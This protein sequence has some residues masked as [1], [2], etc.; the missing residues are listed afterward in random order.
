MKRWIHSS[1]TIR[2]LIEKIDLVVIT[3]DARTLTLSSL[4]VVAASSAGYSKDYDQFTPQE[5]MELDDSELRKLSSPYAL[6]ALMEAINSEGFQYT[7]TKK[8]KDILHD[9]YR[10]NNNAFIQLDPSEINELTQM[11]A[12]CKHVTRPGFRK[13]QPEKNFAEAHGLKMV[14][15]DYLNIIHDIKPNEFKRALK[16]YEKDRLGVPLYE[17]IHDPNGYEL[18]YSKQKIEAKIIIYIKLLVNYDGDF[19]V[20]IISFHDPDAETLSDLE[21]N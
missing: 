20:A 10:N 4:P 7:L 8:Q 5:I 18:K 12:N 17:F 6:D 1:T 16:S 19:N 11:I 9:F 2:N 14:D 3:S 21:D 13:G 15:D